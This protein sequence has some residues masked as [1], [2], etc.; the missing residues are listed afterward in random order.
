MDRAEIIKNALTLLY[1]EFVNKNLNVITNDSETFDDDGVN[2]LEIAVGKNPNYDRI[3]H[4]EW[5]KY[6]RICEKMS[7]MTINTFTEFDGSCEIT[8]QKNRSSKEYSVQW[9]NYKE[10]VKECVETIGTE[11][12]DQLLVVLSINSFPID[13]L[14]R[15][16]GDLNG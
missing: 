12:Y 7:S 1:T 10:M 9:P 16:G 5:D 8:Y 13:L 4:G 6:I 11:L 14:M 15:E 2:F 3:P